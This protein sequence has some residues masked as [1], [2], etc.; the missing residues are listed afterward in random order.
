MSQ[1]P[2]YIFNTLTRT[3]E[4]FEPQTPGFVGMYV[5][6]PTVYGDAHLG[7][8]KSYTTFDVVVRYLRY[9]GLKVRYVQNITDV[10]HLTDDADEGE[11]KLAKQ[12]RLER[13]EPMEVAE[14]YT[15]RYFEDMDRLGLLRPDI[16]PRASGHIPEQIAMIETLIAKGHAY[17]ANGN[18]Y[19][20][21]TSDPNYGQ[22]SGRRLDEAE[23]GTR[24]ATAGDKRH[25]AD[26]ALWKK[27][28]DSHLMKWPSPW[29]VGYPGWHI[30]CSAMS[31]KYLGEN[32]DIHGG[33]L[34]NQFPHHECEIAQSTCAHGTEHPHP[35]VR[36][37]MHNNMVT[38]EGQKMGKSL[39]NAI[40]LR[41]FYD[42]SHKLLSRAWDPQVIR[43]F[44][45]QSHYRSTTDFSEGAL[46]AAENGF[47]N[48]RTYLIDLHKAASQTNKTGDALPLAEIQSETEQAMNDD[49]NT[50]QA[51]ARLFTRIK[52]ARAA[53]NSGKIPVNLDT[54]LSW[55]TRFLDEVLGILPDLSE[56]SG[57]DSETVDG[58]MELILQL[59]REARQSKNWAVADQIRDKLTALGITVKD[60]PTGSSWSR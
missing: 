31:T 28:D 47:A 29:G 52:A 20:D 37:W 15:N 49:F 23:S 34:E 13:L 17:E 10:G 25:P 58:L 12:S 7:H 48:L 21:V 5:C 42:G 8:A 40:S 11:D 43:F 6:G 22:L 32:F 27:A 50:A 39:G 36:Y 26:F 14:K 35:F 4:L 33:G 57:S 9:L 60:H 24:V 55:T 2:I 51:V 41:Q 1:Q 54:F 16:T 30:E 59:R 44:L 53:C 38:L 3:K 46:Q 18:V 45:L 56:A 19:F